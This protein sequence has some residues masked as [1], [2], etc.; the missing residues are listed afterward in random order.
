MYIF[1]FTL[2]TKRFS[3]FP[4]QL[5]TLYSVF[6]RLQLLALSCLI[7][8]EGSGL[9]CNRSVRF[10]RTA[11]WTAAGSRPPPGFMVTLNPGVRCWTDRFLTTPATHST[12]VP[13]WSHWLLLYS[14]NIKQVMPIKE[15]LTNF[16]TR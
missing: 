9:Q 14:G 3:I 8:A 12:H 15:H 7:T 2:T 4:N 5:N 16:W 13:S 1:R 10:V 6:L 11:D